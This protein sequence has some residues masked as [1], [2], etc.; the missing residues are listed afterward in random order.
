MEELDVF[1]SYLTMVAGEMIS[2][3]PLLALVQAADDE[4]IFL[5]A[6]MPEEFS[7]M[8]ELPA[9]NALSAMADALYLVQDFAL[10]HY[11]EN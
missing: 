1:C 4:R 10:N 5:T 8:V 9:G 7:V 3:G 2:G 11:R 6:L